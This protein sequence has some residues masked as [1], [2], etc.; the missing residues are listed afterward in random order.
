MT[1]EKRAQIPG[2]ARMTGINEPRFRVKSGMDYAAFN[3]KAG[4]STVHVFPDAFQAR[5]IRFT[6]SR[7]ANITTWL[8]YR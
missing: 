3:L 7:D 5:W 6:S 2:Q 8:E 1:R 4:K